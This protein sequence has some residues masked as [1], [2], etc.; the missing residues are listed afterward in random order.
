[1]SQTDRQYDLVVWGATGV[2]GRLTAE[3][4]TE[5]YTPDDLSLALGGRDADRLGSIATELVDGSE[6][7][8]DLPIV[9]GDAT[10]PGR[11]LCRGRN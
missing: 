1:V 9:L 6:E 2:A 4:L 8:D 5:Q 3:Y 11:G 7:W 10:E